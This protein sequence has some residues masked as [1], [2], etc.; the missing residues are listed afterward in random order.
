[1]TSTIE[2]NVWPFRWLYR[3]LKQSYQYLKHSKIII[4]VNSIIDTQELFAWILLQQGISE[5][6]F[7]GDLGYKIKRIEMHFFPG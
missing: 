5:P 4:I 3:L 6:V 1:M 7:Y 2:V